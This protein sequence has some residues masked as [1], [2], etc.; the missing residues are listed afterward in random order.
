MAHFPALLTQTES[1][2]LAARIDSH[3][4]EYGFGLWAVEVRGTVPFAGFVGLSV[5]RS[6][7]HGE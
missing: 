2:A 4:E 7:G 3:F 6:G 5:P 1:D